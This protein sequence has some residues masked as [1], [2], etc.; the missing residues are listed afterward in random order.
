MPLPWLRLDVDG[1]WRP[2]GLAAGIA[3][4]GADGAGV[5]VPDQSLAAGELDLVYNDGY[6]DVL[7]SKHPRA[8]GQPGPDVWREI[9][10]DI[11]P[12]FERVRQ[13]GP[14]M[15]AEDARFVME[16]AS[17]PPGEAYFTYSVSPSPTRVAM[18]WRSSTWRRRQPVACA[19]S[20]RR[21]KRGRR[22]S[23]PSIGCAKCSRRRRHSSLC[24]E[25]ESTSS[26][27]RIAR[28]CSSLDIARSSG[29]CVADALP[30]VRE[31]G[32]VELLDT[33]FTTATPFV[34]SAKCP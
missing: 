6:R 4:R 32:F 8:L 28:T 19:P 18:S 16:R 2:G 29:R 24:C 25:V 11:A 7:G 14:L 30:E 3:H 22:R 34:D 27:S 23:M 12:L 15:Y 17:G 31:Q 20:A 9:W 13:G 5:P 1:P 21:T 26:S 33:V 10:P